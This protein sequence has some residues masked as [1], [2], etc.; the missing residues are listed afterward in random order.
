MENRRDGIGIGE[1]SR[2]TGVSERLLRYYEERGLL[3][4]RRSARGHRR[5][6]ATDVS[7]AQLIRLLIDGGLATERILFAFDCLKAHR[8]VAN[9][10]PDLMSTLTSE[11]E[12]ITSQI[13]VLQ[14]THA[15]LGTLV[16]PPAGTSDDASQ[17]VTPR[18][19]RTPHLR[20]P[21]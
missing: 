3:E 12:R 21:R 13:E 1:L 19:S 6:Q 10:C 9:I 7:R 15:Y 11:M 16:G 2:L 18:E 8:D 20:R 14:Q 4:P 17:P 5:Y